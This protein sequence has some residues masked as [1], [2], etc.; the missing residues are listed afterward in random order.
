VEVTTSPSS[1][2]GLIAKD[3]FAQYNQSVARLYAPHDGFREAMYHAGLVTDVPIVPD[4]EIH[5]FTP[6]GDRRPNGWYVFFGDGGAFGNW[7]TGLRETWF[8]HDV[9]RSD[10]WKI[11]AQVKAAQQAMREQRDRKHQRARR[12]A[13]RRWNAASPVTAHRYLKAKGV[14]AHGLRVEDGHL[15]VPVCHDRR[16]WSLQIIS[17]DG[18]KRFLSGGRI[19]GGYFPLG[20]PGRRIWLAEGYAT[21]ATVFEVTGDAVVC[22]FNASNLVKV[23]GH[24][25]DR[26][27][28]H[29]IYIATDNDEA[30]ITAA[31]EAMNNHAL[32]GAKWPDI[33]RADW[34]DYCAVHGPEQTK[35]ALTKGLS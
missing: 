12:I 25:R 7:R 30:G 1:P 28:D 8:R 13:A 32:E 24:I 17:V 16:I 33:V 29:E 20:T 11:K 34:N 2:H 21:A 4:G 9:S 6:E 14:S 18:D 27:T 10:R 35:E 26:F 3:D 22:A 19:S 31:M 15:L 23:A 5:R